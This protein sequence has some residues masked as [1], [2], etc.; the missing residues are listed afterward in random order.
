MTTNQDIGIVGLGAMGLGM[1]QSLRRAGYRVHACDVRPEAAQAFAAEGGVACATPAEA[2]AACDVLISAVVNAAQTEAVLF[3]DRRRRDGAEARQ[4]VRDVLD[5]RSELVDRAR[6]ATRRARPAVPRRA[7][8]RR[9]REGRGRPDDDDDRRPARGVRKG[10][11]RARCDGRQGLPA[12]RPRRQRQQGQD[13][14]PAAGRRAHRRRRRG[15]GARPARRRRPGRA[16]RGHHAQRRQQLDVREPHGPRA[17]GR[18]HAAVGGRHLRQG[19]RA[20]ARHRARDQVPAAAA[21]TAHQM[22]MQASTAGFA[23]RGRLGG[24]QDLPGHRVAGCAG[25][26]GRAD[27]GTS[28]ALRPRSSGCRRAGSARSA[29]VR[30]RWR[31]A[32]RAAARSRSRDSPR[33]AR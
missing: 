16:V 27:A 21:T 6:S 18:L 33:A 32:A 19:P 22:F 25:N 12:R 15:D 8:V 9:R 30:T 2:A 1:A 29:R 14:Q 7:D 10:R 20:R 31:R 23:A 28:D 26:E 11:R 17:G 4:R 5:R 24:D 3:G 13:H